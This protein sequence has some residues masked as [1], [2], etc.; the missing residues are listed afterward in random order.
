M[1]PIEIDTRWSQSVEAHQAT[2]TTLDS[3]TASMAAIKEKLYPHTKLPKIIAVYNE[4]IDGQAHWTSVHSLQ[5]P[6]E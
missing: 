2:Q 5:V 1:H 3:L 4:W 6:G